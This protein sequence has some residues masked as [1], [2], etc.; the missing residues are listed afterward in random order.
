[1]PNFE[2]SVNGLNIPIHATWLK[3]NTLSKAATELLKFI[4]KASV[5][6]D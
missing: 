6:A 4:S 2:I 5:S 3:R 1:M